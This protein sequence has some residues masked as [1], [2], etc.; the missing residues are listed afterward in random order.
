MNLPFIN[1]CRILKGIGI[2][3]KP[4]TILICIINRVAIIGTISITT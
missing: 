2:L 3:T 4:F 1:P